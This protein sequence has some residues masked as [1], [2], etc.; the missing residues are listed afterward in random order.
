MS[1]SVSGEPSP[2]GRRDGPLSTA[3][4]SAADWQLLVRLPAEVMIAS[5][6]AAPGSPG[7]A[8]AES[9]A[10][11][12]GI[13]AGRA[14]DSDLV[15]AVVAAIYAEAADHSTLA[16]R[17]GRG[18]HAARSLAACRR[19]VRILAGQADPADSA[20]YRQWVQSVAARVCE[21]GDP[22]GPVSAPDELARRRAYLAD[23]RRALRLG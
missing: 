6:S 21:S 12:E 5:T 16:A 4:F 13:A 20:A 8:V 3:T 1:H 11:L 18:Q 10:G 14:F 23:L 22:D 2:V 17:P 7:R 19:A 15:R 9:L